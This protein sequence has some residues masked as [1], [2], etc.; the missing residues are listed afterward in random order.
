[1]AEHR[2]VDARVVG[3]TPISHPGDEDLL[4]E[5][6]FNIKHLCGCEIIVLGVIGHTQVDP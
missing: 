1:M 6:F 5:V 3:S 2:T 4:I